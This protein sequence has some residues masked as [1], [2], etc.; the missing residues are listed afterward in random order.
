MNWLKQNPIAVV[1]IVVALIGTGATSYL[2]VDATTRR[3]EAQA[4]L[5]AQLQKLKQFQNQKPFPTEQSLKAIKDSLEEYRSELGKYRTALAAMEKPLSSINPQEFQ[6]DLRKAVDELRKKAIEKGV[7]LPDNFFYGFDEYQAT[8]PSQQEVGELNREF[9]IMRR[10]TDELVDLKIVSI[11]SLKRQEIAVK[12]SAAMPAQ[13]ANSAATPGPK[14]PAISTKTFIITFTAPQEKLLTAFNMVQE[15]DEFLLTRSLTLDNTSPQ[16]PLRAQLGDSSKPT[17]IP[18]PGSSE[19]NSDTIQAILGRES[20][21]ASLTIEILDFPDWESK[22]PAQS[23]P[24][25]PPK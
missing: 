21:T 2:A 7:T 20:V 5:D 6:D 17:G 4:N 14:A 15:A 16:P 9:C 11:A 3:D 18:V 1:L 22:P 13:P 8:P 24:T 19:K 23:K 25:P 12:A 10:I